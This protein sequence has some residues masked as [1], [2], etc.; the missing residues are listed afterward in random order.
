MEMAALP[1]SRQRMEIDMGRSKVS[2]KMKLM[3]NKGCLIGIGVMLIGFIV[4]NYLAPCQR[5]S[6]ESPSVYIEL[7]RTCKHLLEQ[8]GL[9]DITTLIN[10]LHE[11][12]P[13]KAVIIEPRHANFPKRV[14][15]YLPRKATVRRNWVHI[16]FG[17]GRLG[18]FGVSIE[19]FPVDSRWKIKMYVS[20]ANSY[21]L[22]EGDD[23]DL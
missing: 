13:R 4:A 10:A 16:M 18:G 14:L 22:W 8:N 2:A 7:I 1:R 19:F 17:V 21:L 20:E 12:P 11:E 3:K 5:F 6:R 9:L 15:R 23:S